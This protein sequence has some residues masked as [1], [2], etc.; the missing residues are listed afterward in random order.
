MLVDKEIGALQDLVRLETDDEFDFNLER[1]TPNAEGPYMKFKARVTITLA[2]GETIVT[3]KDM[4]AAGTGNM[5][6]EQVAHQFTAVT[7]EAPGAEKVAQSSDSVWKPHKAPAA[8][9]P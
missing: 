1:A 4:F 6:R 7:E 3:Y 9:R 5:P 8:G 2:S